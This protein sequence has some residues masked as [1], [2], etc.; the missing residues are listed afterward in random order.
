MESGTQLA[1]D[2]RAVGSQYLQTRAPIGPGPLA[3]R[4]LLLHRS[5]AKAGGRRGPC[6]GCLATARGLAS[7]EWQRS[8]CGTIPSL[9]RLGVRADHHLRASSEPN[10]W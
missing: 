9:P 2:V 1:G 10:L 6:V 5:I 3:G 4:K 8:D 7:A